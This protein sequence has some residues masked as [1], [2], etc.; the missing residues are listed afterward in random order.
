MN[1]HERIDAAENR[2]YFLFRDVRLAQ[3]FTT[4]ACAEQDPRIP[5]DS[6]GEPCDMGLSGL[7]ADFYE[8]IRANQCEAARGVLRQIEL[9]ASEIIA[10]LEAAK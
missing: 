7:G 9:R 3:E 4:C 2:G 6:G 5:R 8:A 1:W 10:E